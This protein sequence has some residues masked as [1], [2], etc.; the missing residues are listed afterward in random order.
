MD[1]ERDAK[2]ITARHGEAK[3]LLACATW[4][5]FL[6][7]PMFKPA[8]LLAT[9]FLGGI[10]I[11]SAGCASS[12]ER[13]GPATQAAYR[14][15]AEKKISEVT[16]SLSPAARE[17]LK[18]NLKFDPE[19]LRK[20]MERALSAYQIID[21]GQKGSLPAMEVIVTNM[22]VRSNFSAVAFGIMAGTDSLEADVVIKDAA[23]KELDR[24]KV[25]ASYGLGGLAGGQDSARM[26]WIYE[27]FS[28]Q[29]VQE[30]TGVKKG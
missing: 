17:K 4:E 15:S 9:A 3:F 27:E 28:K 12:V 5:Y 24:F 18:D 19:E 7:V 1:P 22:R 11:F 14:L 13:A 26:S 16:V 6:Y 25:S 10:C 23:G 29:A 8:P 20:H 21:P 2:V 30:V